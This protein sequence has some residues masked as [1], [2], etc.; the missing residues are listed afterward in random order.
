MPGLE[1]VPLE[2]YNELL[3]TEALVQLSRS[4]KALHSRASEPYCWAL[5]AARDFGLDRREALKLSAHPAAQVALLG[6]TAPCHH[7]V[8]RRRVASRAAAFWARLRAFHASA[9]LPLELAPPPA[10]AELAAAEA[11]AGLRFP[12][13]LR[14]L[15]A[16]GGGQRG[17]LGGGLRGALG[18]WFV[19]DRAC[20]LSL[21]HGGLPSLLRLHGA[22]CAGSPRTAGLFP[23]AAPLGWG[24]SGFYFVQCGEAADR[25]AVYC[26]TVA[27]SAGGRAGISELWPAAAGAAAVAAAPGA[28]GAGE[29]ARED[30]LLAWCEAWAG[31]LEGGGRALARVPPELQEALV[32][33]AGAAPAAVPRTPRAIS[34]WPT[35]G[36]GTSHAVTRGVHLF[37]SSLFLPGLSRPGALLFAY[38]V[39]LWRD[40]GA[41]GAPGDLR[42]TMRHWVI[43]PAGGAAQ[44]VHG[45]GVVGLFPALPASG[46]EHGSRDAA[47]EYASQTAFAAPRGN[48]MR[49]TLEFEEAGGGGSVHVQ[50]APL[51]FQ[52]LPPFL[53]A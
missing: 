49:G 34:A 10:A 6:V 53:Y 35:A 23:V 38:R 36:P 33:S 39:F 37:V 46:A 17:S 21:L 7:A 5:A 1:D 15:L 12:F 30:D 31:L 4:S 2:C 51:E 25:G 13:A 11:A 50:M 43:T 26:G 41:P 8:V 24:G 14:A 16:A 52:G 18:A 29:A 22:L 45:E 32:E 42:L 27:R 3:D 20:S 28:L 47:F 19:Y 40:A 9:G 48:T 44:E